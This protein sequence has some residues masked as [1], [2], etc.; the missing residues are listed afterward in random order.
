MD[1]ELMP[2]HDPRSSFPRS[3]TKVGVPRT[4]NRSTSSPFSSMLTSP[5]SAIP[6][7]ESAALSTA[8][9]M[10][11]HGTHQGAQKSRS[12]GVS[13]LASSWSKFDPFISI[14]WLGLPLFT[15]NEMP[16][17]EKS[18]NTIA[19][20]KIDGESHKRLG[21]SGCSLGRHRLY[22]GRN[23]FSRDLHRSWASV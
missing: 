8:F 22:P 10:I 19:C 9:F 3:R 11:T 1:A 20:S 12:K 17:P 18:F 23:R 13:H 6:A 7:K 2:V 14:G 21:L 16:N 15:P 5:T 4:P